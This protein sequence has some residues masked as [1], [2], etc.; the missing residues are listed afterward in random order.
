MRLLDSPVPERVSS[1]VGSGSP[2]FQHL[3]GDSA[4][5]RLSADTKF[6]DEQAAQT[7]IMRAILPFPAQ[8]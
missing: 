8:V 6:C 4:T 1:A 3:G 7:R 5:A 2:H